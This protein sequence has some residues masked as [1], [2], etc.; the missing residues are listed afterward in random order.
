M[1]H[2][3]LDDLLHAGVGGGQD[4]L[5]VGAASPGQ[6]TNAAL[7][8]LAVFIGGDLTGNKD[9]AVGA[10]S[11]GLWI[12]SSFLSCCVEGAGH[13]VPRSGEETYVGGGSCTFK[14][15]IGLVVVF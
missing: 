3:D 15:A 12:V 5:D 14:L 4:S 1:T 6:V 8:Q 11:L 10:D 13:R 2:I 9:L 7:N